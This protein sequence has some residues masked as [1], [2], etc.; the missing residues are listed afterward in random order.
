MLKET[1]TWLQNMGVTVIRQGGSFTQDDY[2]LW[3]NW[4]GPVYERPSI[5]AEWGASL[6]GGWCVVVPRPRE[7]L[8]HSHTA[9]SRA[10]TFLC[11][12]H[13]VL[14]VAAAVVFLPGGG[15]GLGHVSQG[16][17]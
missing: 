7:P 10:D 6:V 8:L 15:G 14:A 1:V 4:R 11:P 5:G 12:V 3:K 9:L 17:L 16:S 13:P 2:Y